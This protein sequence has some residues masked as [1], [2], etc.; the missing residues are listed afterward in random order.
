MIDMGK[1]ISD[2]NFVKVKNNIVATCLKT[3]KPT[4]L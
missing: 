1:Q 2:I 4:V 3:D